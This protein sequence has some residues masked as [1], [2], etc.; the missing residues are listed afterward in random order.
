MLRSIHHAGIYAGTCLKVSGNRIRQANEQLIVPRCCITR[1]AE[2]DK[3]I[4]LTSLWNASKACKSLYVSSATLK[5]KLK[6]AGS[7]TPE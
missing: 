1:V 4:V 2:A 6:Q 7:E 5:F 3:L